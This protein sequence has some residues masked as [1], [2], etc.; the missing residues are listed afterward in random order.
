MENMTNNNTTEYMIGV[1]ILTILAPVGEFVCR[2]EPGETLPELRKRVANNLTKIFEMARPEFVNPKF[3]L[4]GGFVCFS[5][6]MWEKVANHPHGGYW[7]RTLPD[8]K[9]GYEARQKYVPATLD[10]DYRLVPVTD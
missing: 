1:W 6:E 4:S 9:C 8:I 10:E 5:H 3:W 7:F 2:G